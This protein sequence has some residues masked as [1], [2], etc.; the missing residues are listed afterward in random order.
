MS[1]LSR[2]ESI[3]FQRAMYR[4]WLVSVL[5]GSRYVDGFDDYSE[6]YPEGCGLQLEE[7]WKDQKSFLQQFS[8]QELF[9][10]DCLARYLVFTA[11]WATT[12][13]DDGS[14]RSSC[15]VC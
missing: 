7:S 15:G 14:V 13:E 11:N 9:Q 3:R 2:V 6:E 8:T 12:A 10:I 5:F 1:R 4:I